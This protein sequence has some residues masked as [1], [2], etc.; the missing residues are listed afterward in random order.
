MNPVGRVFSRLQLGH[1]P[2]LRAALSFDLVL[3][4]GIVQLRGG[5]SPARWILGVVQPTVFTSVALLA[6]GPNGSADVNRIA[7]G[8]G[9]VAL[10]G[11]TIWGAGSVMRSERREGTLAAIV[12]RPSS[13]PLILA[14]KSSTST[15]QTALLIGLSVFVT[16][17]IFGHRLTLARPVE[18]AGVLLLAV[19]SASILGLMLGCLFVLTRAAQRISEALTYPIFIV[20]GLMVPLSLLPA[21]IRPVSWLVSLRW[22]GDLLRSAMTGSATR[23]SDWLWLLLTSFAYLLLTRY[24]FAAVLRRARREGTLEL[25]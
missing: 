5:W 23:T 7:L 8:A 3:S 16:A 20:G 11:A 1:L 4:A 13:L 17:L 15:L 19:I 24:A 10:W 12:V 18:F 21:W 6:V 2:R 22:G 14:G 25:Y 9:L